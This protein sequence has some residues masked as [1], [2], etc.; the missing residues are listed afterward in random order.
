MP[1]PEV[2]GPRALAYLYIRQIPHVH[3]IANYY[4]YC[5]LSDGQ[6]TSVLSLLT[7]DLLKVSLFDPP[8]TS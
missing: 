6:S 3:G 2:A 5:A 7:K 4:I 8:S 1:K